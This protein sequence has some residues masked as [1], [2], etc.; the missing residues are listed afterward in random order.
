MTAADPT[1]HLDLP[2]VAAF[3]ERVADESPAPREPLDDTLGHLAG[4]GLPPGTVVVL[5][6]ANSAHTVQLHL[7]ALLLGLVP[8]AVSPS[9]P[10]ARVRELALR[11]GARAVVARRLVPEILGVAHARTVGHAEAVLLPGGEQRHPAGR[12]LLSTSGTSGMASACLHRLGGLL[13]NARRHAAS[14]GMGGDDVVLVSLPLYYSFALV[15]QVL[16][17]YVTGA[18]VVVSGP[19]FSPGA[20]RRTLLK[21][22]VTHSSLT[23]SVAR[24][25]TDDEE[26][27]PAGLRVLTV[28]GDR[29][30][31]EAVARLLSA[32]PSG[33]LYLTY[34]LAEAGPRV[35]TLAAHAEPAHRHASVGLPLPGVRAFLRQP[36]EASCGE[37]MVESDTVLVRKLGGQAPGG[38]GLVRPGLV[39][40]GD[41]FHIDDDGYLYFR[42]R[43]SDFVMIRGEK[44]SLVS[45][46]QAV[47]SLPQVAHC[48]PRVGR[49][50]DGTAALDLEIVP[51]DQ[52]PGIEE[53]IRHALR[54][55][56]L[57]AER[58]RRILITAPDP[59]LFQK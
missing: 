6:L 45:V 42:G 57:P 55:M 46:R 11:L 31:A 7:S 41:R 25:L 43:L 53:S 51:A 49:D 16:A 32:R 1:P 28:G 9:T 58:P 47:Q 22:G 30:P 59:L 48:T 34:G 56:L 40:T 4:L 29:L 23:P 15:A 35:S 21:H 36:D 14:V 44:V 2:E 10:P 12:V 38:R 39:A 18:R 17:S 20:Y 3:L 26:Q 33:Q 19:P 13:R 54:T 8:L 37:L 52:R 24:R 5:A 50:E 27:L